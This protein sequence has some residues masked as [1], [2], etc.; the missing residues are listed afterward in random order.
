MR[1]MIR[2]VWVSIAGV[3]ELLGTARARLA[4][5]PGPRTATRCAAC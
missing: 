5:E 3:L 1:S 2:R 4:Q